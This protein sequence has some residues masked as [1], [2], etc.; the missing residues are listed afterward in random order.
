MRCAV[1][2]STNIWRISA[3]KK[4]NTAIVETMPITNQTMS[5]VPTKRCYTRALPSR[6]TASIV[7]LPGSS[8]VAAARGHELLDVAVVFQQVVEL[9]HVV[10]RESRTLRHRSP[11]ILGTLV[12]EEQLVAL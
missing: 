6:Q 5:Q 2:P 8:G 3:V 7:E 12:V 10:D 11:Q 1:R 4:A 9:D